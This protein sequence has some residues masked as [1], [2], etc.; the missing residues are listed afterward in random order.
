MSARSGRTSARAGFTLAEAVLALTVFSALLGGFLLSVDRASKACDAAEMS[1]ELALDAFDAVRSITRELSRTGYRELDGSPV[2]VLFE[3]GHPGADHPAF[4]H[5]PPGSG[6]EVRE[7]LYR[8]P[9]DSDGDG[10]PDVDANGE[11]VW[12]ATWYGLLCLR[13]SDG[14]DALVRRADDGTTTVLARDVARLVFET[15]GETEFAIPPDALR[16][17]LTLRRR[18]PDGREYEYETQRVVRLRNGGL[19]P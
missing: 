19:S 10:W 18:G 7:I 3:D 12:D 13:L 16:F 8:L 2:P 6:E 17:T 9:L 5:E 14:T 4:A 11:A 1:H 15:P